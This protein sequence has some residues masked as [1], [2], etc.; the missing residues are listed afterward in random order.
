MSVLSIC[1][2]VAR[3]VGIEVPSSVVDSTNVTARRLLAL[4]VRA[5]ER[6]RRQYP[7]PELTRLASFT[8]VDGQASY[9][10]PLDLDWQNFETHWDQTNEWSLMGP[11]TPQEWQL[12][13]QGLVATF[14][15]KV[16]RFKGWANKQF[17]IFP[18][19]DTGDAGNI[20]SFEYQTVA[21]FRPVSEWTTGTVYAAQSVVYYEGNIYGSNAGGTAGATP[22]THITGS[23]SDGGVAWIWANYYYSQPFD[24]SNVGILPESLLELDLI[25]RFRRATGASY[26]DFKREADEAWQERISTYE[27]GRTLNMGGNR[28]QGQFIG[29]ENIPETGLGS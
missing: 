25:W 15:R 7:W 27:P 19:P 6:R 2:N 29:Y 21:C 11:L 4:L 10:V 28:L 24:D 1:Q 22:P 16:Y 23:T 20:L 8:L 3:E 5:A 9:A 26:D 17:F 12:H 18:T 13:E 14:P